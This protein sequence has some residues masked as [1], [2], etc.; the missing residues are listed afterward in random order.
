MEIESYKCYNWLS[1]TKVVKTMWDV[2]PT[3]SL[4]KTFYL[5]TCGKWKFFTRGQKD[6]SGRD[7]PTPLLINLGEI[8]YLLYLLH[9]VLFKF[10]YGRDNYKFF[11]IQRWGEIESNLLLE[12][13]SLLCRSLLQ[14]N[15]VKLKAIRN[16]NDK[17]K[18]LI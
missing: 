3:C 12:N 11:K 16:R 9:E 7:A 13:F 10:L 14:Y 5:D 2:L 6:A 4:D 18:P 8:G 15:R 1:S 17:I